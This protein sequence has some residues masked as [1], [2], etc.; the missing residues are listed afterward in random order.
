MIPVEEAYQEPS[1]HGQAHA[2][3]QDSMPPTGHPLTGQIFES[4]SAF[5]EVTRMHGY[6][7]VG[8]TW[9]T[10]EKREKYNREHKAS[11]R[12]LHKTDSYRRELRENIKRIYAE[13]KNGKRGKEDR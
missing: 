2:V 5:R 12:D 7:E 10:K 3:I 1:T 13:Y 8:D 11:I 9:S 6:E 4:K